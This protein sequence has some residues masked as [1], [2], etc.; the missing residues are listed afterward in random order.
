MTAVLRDLLSDL[1]ARFRAAGIESPDA[2]ARLLAAHALGLSREDLVL[3]ARREVSDDGRAR[4]ESCA[5]R[6]LRREPFQ[7]FAIRRQH[8]SEPRLDCR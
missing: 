2:D 5:V 3:D 7:A 6:R 1:A 4:L 8:R